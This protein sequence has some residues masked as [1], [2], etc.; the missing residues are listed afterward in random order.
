VENKPLPRR[1]LTDSDVAAHASTLGGVLQLFRRDDAAVVKALYE[2]KTVDDVE[3]LDKVTFFDQFFAF[4]Q[5]LRILPLL[6]EL[7]SRQRVRASIPWIA[8]V[9]VYVMRIVLGIP[10]IPQTEGL[11]LTD[12]ALMVLF[13]LA[14]FVQRGV[15]R[16]GLSRART[17]PEVRGAFS[18]EV[19]V[20]TLVRVSLT[21]L[22]RTFNAVIG[23][24]AQAGYFPKKVHAVVDC[25]DF[26]TTPKYRTLDGGPVSSVTRKKRPQH[27]HNR[28][29]PKVATTV[30][31]WKIWLMF[32]PTSGIPI[33]VYIDRINVDDRVW[34]WALVIQGKANLGEG[35]LVSVSFD[36]GFWDGQQLYLVA[37]EVPF[38]IPGKSDLGITQEARRMAI[39]AYKRYQQGL[40]LRDV[41]AATRTVTVVSGKG[42]KR[43]EEQKELIVF[44][45][46]KLDCDTYAEEAPESRVNS[47]SFVANKLNAAVVLEDP[48]Y[49]DPPEGEKYL[50]ILTCA[51]METPRD[52]LFA[53]DRFDNRSVIENSGNKEAKQ[54]WKLEAPL[55]KSEAAVYLHTFM[56]FMMMALMAAFRAQEEADNKA[57][58]QGKDTGMERYRREVERANR[59]KILV[60]D[61]ECYAVLW[62]WELALLGGMRLRHYASESVETILKRYGVVTDDRVRPTPEGESP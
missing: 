23:I 37:K 60:R 27:S 56:V 7:N 39:E 22:A 4:L 8:M 19:M 30:W 24:L 33:A 52:V 36:R 51:P 48:S 11:V 46:Q 38:F 2:T 45:I 18:G 28:H 12:P 10:S 43:R 57:L 47:K 41:L 54:A 53:Y 20:D 6:E 34:M 62:A 14:A 31:G 58:E 13:G 21:S 9:G 26:E 3:A 1:K 25:T 35:R 16:R 49:P 40:P 44:G 42:K 59:D 17:L 5:S 29:A 15:T 55:E 61:G 32:C 50:T